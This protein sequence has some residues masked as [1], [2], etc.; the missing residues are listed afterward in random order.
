[1]NHFNAFLEK[2]LKLAIEAHKGQTD[3]SGLSYI[4]H[5]L[6]V[7][8]KVK[9]EKAKIVAILHDI[10]E[11]TPITIFI[12]QDLGF[13]NEIIEAIELLTRKKSQDYFEYIEILSQNY[14][15]REVKIADLEHNLDVIRFKKFGLFE[16]T[17]ITKHH[18]ALK[19]IQRKAG[20]K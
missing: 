4:L 11:D 2:A 13:S 12:L 10:I 20:S 18:K 9:S 14:L 1:M 8:F 15:A 16:S 3:L 5:P 19:L 7:M 6:N 17:Q